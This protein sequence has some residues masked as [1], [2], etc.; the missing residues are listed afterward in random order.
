MNTEPKKDNFDFFME[1]ISLLA[2]SQGFYGRLLAEIKENQ[3][4][5]K[6]YINNKAPVFKDSLDIIM[7]LEG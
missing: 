2:K 6:E 3:K 1:A 7:W 4:E 5:Y